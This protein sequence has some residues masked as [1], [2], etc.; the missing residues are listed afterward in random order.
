MLSENEIDFEMMAHLA[1]PKDL[2]DILKETNNK[3]IIEQLR[4]NTYIYH[5]RKNIDYY[6][7]HHYITKNKKKIVKW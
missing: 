3:N 2:L 5:F 1:T 4:D 6:Y 7:Q